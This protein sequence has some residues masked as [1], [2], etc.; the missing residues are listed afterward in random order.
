MHTC[1]MIQLI[2]I[3]TTAILRSWLSLS[4]VCSSWWLWWEYC[5]EKQP[6]LLLTLFLQ[7]CS[8]VEDRWSWASP[9]RSACYLYFRYVS[10][11]TL[12][13][14]PSC[15]CRCSSPRSGRCWARCPGSG[16]PTPRRTSSLLLPLLISVLLNNNSSSKAAPHWHRWPQQPRT[17][18]TR[19]P[20]A[21]Q[22]VPPTSLGIP[23]LEVLARPGDLSSSHDYLRLS[24]SLS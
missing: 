22:T 21:C 14:L 7:L 18:P 2:L 20:A 13:R 19:A 5:L 10:S 24:F 9:C 17:P 4:K 1:S 16:D 8:P 11:R 23:S 6:R 15:R 3:I 12:C